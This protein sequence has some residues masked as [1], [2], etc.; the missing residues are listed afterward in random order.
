MKKFT[1]LGGVFMIS[2][3]LESTDSPNLL[4]DFLLRFYKKPK[5]IHIVLVNNYDFS[6]PE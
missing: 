3:S 5:F 2:N 4:T 1:L 6:V